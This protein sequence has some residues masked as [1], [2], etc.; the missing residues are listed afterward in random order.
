MNRLISIEHRGE[1][2]WNQNKHSCKIDDT[3]F[4]KGWVNSQRHT[5][6]PWFDGNAAG[7]SGICLEVLGGLIHT[8]L[9]L[10]AHSISLLIN[11][12]EPV[13]FEDHSASAT[14]RTFAEGVMWSDVRTIGGI[15]AVTDIF[16]E[17][18]DF[19]SHD[20]LEE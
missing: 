13:V 14:L 9:L 6:H 5:V 4:V 15:V 2:I 7:Q 16:I 20:G 12:V 18:F 17:A 3:S 19:H 10:F 1:F 8:Q 11:S